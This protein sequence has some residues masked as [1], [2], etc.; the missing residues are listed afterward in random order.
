MSLLEVKTSELKRIAEEL[1]HKVAQSPGFFKRS[2]VVLGFEQ[3]S[4]ASC[5]TIDLQ[6]L[7]RICR[8]LEL[9]PAAIRGGSEILADQA[10]KLGL[11]VLPKAKNSARE[12]QSNRESAE[13][14]KPVKDT[15]PTEEA[16]TPTAAATDEQTEST[17]PSPNSK[18]I[19]TPIR[20][21]QQIYARGGDLIV[22]TSVS[23]G[24]EVLADGNIHIYGPLRGRALAGVQGDESARI[25]CSSQEAELV[26]VAGHF[27]VDEVLRNKNW[28]QAVQ[29]FIEDGKL[30]TKP[31]V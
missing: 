23:A 18:V 2:A 4:S 27:L 1:E 29:I 22:L 31:L 7:H 6:E 16:A 8:S 10:L 26:S 28:K 12:Q 15:V 19:T 24:A 30:E 5:D 21:G 25:F 17:Q 13:T 11:A 14:N 3:L 9:L 20:S